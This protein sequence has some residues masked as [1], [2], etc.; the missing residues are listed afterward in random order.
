MG[1]EN[2]G[3]KREEWGGR[4]RIVSACGLAMTLGAGTD[5]F[6]VNAL[7]RRGRGRI[8]SACGLAMTRGAGTDRFGMNALR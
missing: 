5:R 4:G 1:D 8:A 2:T 7:R 6:G 3:E